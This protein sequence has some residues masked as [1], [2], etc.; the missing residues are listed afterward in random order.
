MNGINI[1]KNAWNQMSKII[2]LTKN[3]YGFIYSAS[4]GG[5]NGFIFELNLLNENL[6]NQ[7]IQRNNLRVNSN[8]V[9]IKI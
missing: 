3:K 2:N 7:I 8:L 4:S 5:C 6:Y 9:L 1:T